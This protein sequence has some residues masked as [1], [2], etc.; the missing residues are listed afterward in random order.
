[1]IILP[2]SFSKYEQDIKSMLINP[3]RTFL[4]KTIFLSLLRFTTTTGLLE[5]VQNQ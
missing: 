3:V 2:L 4:L 1:M 5:I